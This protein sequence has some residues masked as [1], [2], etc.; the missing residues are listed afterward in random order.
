[1]FVRTALRFF[2]LLKSFEKNIKEGS[3]SFRLLYAA[4][5]HRFMLK[6]IYIGFLLTGLE[7]ILHRSIRLNPLEKLCTTRNL[8]VNVNSK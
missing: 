4:I 7:T 8:I 1:M 6:Y 2:P 3:F 5:Y